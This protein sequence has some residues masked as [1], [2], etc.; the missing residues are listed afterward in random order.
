MQGA[1]NCLTKMCKVGSWVVVICENFN[2]KFYIVLDCY[3]ES[4]YRIVHKMDDGFMKRWYDENRGDRIYHS[5]FSGYFKLKALQ[6]G[7]LYITGKTNWNLADD[8]LNDQAEVMCQNT[9]FLARGF[10][11]RHFKQKKNTDFFI[12][13]L[14]RRDSEYY[15]RQQGYAVMRSLEDIDED[16]MAN[17]PLPLYMAMNSWLARAILSSILRK[18]KPKKSYFKRLDKN[19]Q[20][21]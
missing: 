19:S 3:P 9:R 1:T 4:L 12:S 2:E 18:S 13:Q 14:N 5:S 11:V 8:D 10:C 17:A 15:A 16:D 20:P 7:E 21:S 6:V